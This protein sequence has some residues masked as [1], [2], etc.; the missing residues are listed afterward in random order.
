[1]FIIMQYSVKR[2]LLIVMSTPF[3]QGCISDYLPESPKQQQE[4]LTQ[5]AVAAGSGCRQVGRSIENCFERYE[6]L[7][8]AGILSGWREMDDYMRTNKMDSQNKE[9]VPVYGSDRSDIKFDANGTSEKD[10]KL[11]SDEKKEIINN[12][13]TVPNNLGTGT[14]GQIPSNGNVKSA[15]PLGQDGKKN[16]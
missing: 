11:N 8:R 6:K 9:P 5:E 15:N 16:P 1:M 14:N 4:R 2:W 12:G 3:L 7:P 10:V 13:S